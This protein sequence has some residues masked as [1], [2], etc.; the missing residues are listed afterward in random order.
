MGCP[1]QLQQPR[2]HGVTAAGCEHARTSSPPA[3]PNPPIAP[4]GQCPRGDGAWKFLLLGLGSVLPAQ[5]PAPIPAGGTEVPQP[6]T[7]PP[8]ARG[9][10]CGPVRAAGTDRGRGQSRIVL[11]TKHAHNK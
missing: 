5:Q 3:L 11:G 1:D 8:P 9:A 4:L 2:S 10:R 7:S 6:V